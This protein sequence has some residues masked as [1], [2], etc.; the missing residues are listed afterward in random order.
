MSR[1]SERISKWNDLRIFKG[2]RCAWWDTDAYK[3][4]KG[5]VLERDGVW[6]QLEDDNG[7][8]HKKQVMELTPLMS[9]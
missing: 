8:K 1:A 4:V 7:K 5:F 9:E 6:C 3:S 2:A